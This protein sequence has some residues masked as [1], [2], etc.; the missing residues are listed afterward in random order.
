MTVTTSWNEE[1]VQEGFATG[2]EQGFKQG[3]EQGFKQGF[4]QGQIA[5]LK[6]QFIRRFGQLTAECERQL[7]ALGTNQLAILGEAMFDFTS[8]ADLAAWL[9][10]NISRE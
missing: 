4:K 9:E 1:G 7:E 6:R 2:F 8:A 5:L 10:I 3:F